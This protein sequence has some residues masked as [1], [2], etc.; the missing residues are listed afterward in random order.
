[1]S[2]ITVSII[3]LA[4]NHEKFIAQAI[5]GVI[6]QKTEFSWELLIADDCSSDGTEDICVKYSKGDIRIK[7]F[8]NKVNLGANK[9]FLDVYGK[10]SGRYIALCEG[11]DYWIDPCKLQKQVEFLNA[12]NDFVICFH[13]VYE[14]K[15]GI[16]NPNSITYKKSEFNID[17]LA[18]GNFIHTPSVLFVNFG[19]RVIPSYFSS[20]YVGDYMLHMQTSKF[21]KIKMIE[22]KMAV[23]RIHD[24]GSWSSKKDEFVYLKIAEYL[25]LFLQDDF[26]KEVK[27][28]LKNRLLGVYKILFSLTKKRIYLLKLTRMSPIHSLKFLLSKV[29]YAAD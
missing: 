21:G 18:Q 19:D 13:D 24:G 2:S 20:V 14:L 22:E 28:I 15:Q 12:N 11:D 5:E 29:S 1:M 8:R 4:Y 26:R 16:L 17:D 9:N 6:M 23:Y 3:M 7:Y 25:E 10:C 27:R